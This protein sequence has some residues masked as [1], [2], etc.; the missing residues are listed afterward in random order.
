MTYFINAEGIKLKIP[1][2][3]N[4]KITDYIGKRI[5][6]GV[7]PEDIHDKQ[8]VS[9]AIPSNTIKAKV[10]VIEPLGAEIFIYLACGNNSL[11]GKMDSRTQVEIEQDIE[12]VIDMEKTHIFDPTTLLAIV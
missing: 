3:F 11:V 12:I 9:N 6:F 4:S 2:D 5:I 7:R 1:E 10:E 8:F